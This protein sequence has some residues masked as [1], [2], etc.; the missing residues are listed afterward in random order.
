M[1]VD[2]IT[3]ATI[4]PCES[5]KNTDRLTLIRD[6]EEHGSFAPREYQVCPLRVENT[7]KASRRP[8]RSGR[9]TWSAPVTPPARAVPTPRPTFYAPG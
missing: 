8:Q 1:A 9:P 3:A 4:G 7:A 5:C 6:W 2:P